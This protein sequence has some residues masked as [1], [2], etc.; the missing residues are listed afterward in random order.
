[1]RTIED[2]YIEL[3]DGMYKAAN[4]T[5]GHPLVKVFILE[6]VDG[7]TGT[8]SCCPSNKRYDDPK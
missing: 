3:V 7:L 5:E 2:R 4:I 1:L 8:I 6:A